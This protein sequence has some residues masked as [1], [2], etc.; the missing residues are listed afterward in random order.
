MFLKVRV[1]YKS[2]YI[3]SELVDL[4]KQVDILHENKLL[5]LKSQC[6]LILRN[7]NTILRHL[8]PL[9]IFDTTFFS[10]DPEN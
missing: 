6:M 9:F 1:Q 3:N 10:R 5:Q 4:K 8:H 2:N 7:W